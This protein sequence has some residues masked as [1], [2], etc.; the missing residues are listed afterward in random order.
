ML[1]NIISFII[2][3]FIIIIITLKFNKLIIYLN[4]QFSK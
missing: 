1:E 2:I 3:S 4:C